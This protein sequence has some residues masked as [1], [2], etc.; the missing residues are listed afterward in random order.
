ML[1]DGKSAKKKLHPAYRGPFVIA[2]FAGSQGKSYTL[3]QVNGNP[4]PRSY[5]R[6]HLKPFTLRTRYLYIKNKK[7]ILPYQNLYTGQV[8]YKLPKNIILDKDYQLVISYKY[9]IYLFC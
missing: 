9:L 8:I 3:R 6:D 7:R 1:Y 2:G 4:I 5:Y